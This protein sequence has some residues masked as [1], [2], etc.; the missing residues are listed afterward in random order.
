MRWPRTIATRPSSS[1]WRSASSAGRGNSDSSSRN[2]T[3][4]WARLASPGPGA[5]PPPTRPD[6]RDRVV[7]RAERPLGDQPGA[8]AAP[9]DAVDARDLDRLRRASAAA[10]STAGAARASSCPCRAAR[11][12]AGCGRRRR[13]SRAPRSTSVWPRTSARSSCARGRRRGGRLGVGAGGG[14]A[15]RRA[16]S[17]TTSREVLDRRPRRA[18]RPAPPRARAAR[19]TTSPRSPRARGALGDRE[20]AAARP[21]LAAERRARRRRRSASS[22]LGRDLPPAA[23]TARRRCAR[24]KPGPALRRSAGARLTVMRSQRE[25]EAELRSAARTRS[26]AS[27]TARSARPTIVK[28]AGP[29]RMSTS[30]VTRRGVEAVDREGGDAGE[31]RRH[32]RPRGVTVERPSHRSAQPARAIRRH[33]SALRRIG[34]TACHV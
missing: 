7:R 2:S 29:A 14:A 17:P 12:A 20:R 1:G 34:T 11:R 24:S 19:G 33:G 16:G 27:R 30:T 26:R 31:H 13:R 6:A 21:Q 10:G 18:R 9:G 8:A 25:L 23:R 15:R 5:A 4:W 3:P 28:P 22:A 32:A